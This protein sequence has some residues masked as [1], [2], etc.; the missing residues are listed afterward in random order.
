MFMGVK[1]QFAAVE[2]LGW[3]ESIDFMTEVRRGE[4]G[5]LRAVAE[6]TQPWPQR[7]GSSV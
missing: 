5:F 2:G 6:M 1:R 3:R 7:H 4:I